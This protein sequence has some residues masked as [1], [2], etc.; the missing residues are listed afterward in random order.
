M[1]EEEHSGQ[2]NGACK[3]LK[4]EKGIF[5]KKTR[6]EAKEAVVE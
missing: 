1:A 2:T 5:H 6:K 4:Q 3:T